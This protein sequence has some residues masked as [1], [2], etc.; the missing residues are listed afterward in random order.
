MCIRDSPY[1]SPE[2]LDSGEVD[3]QSDLWSLAVMLYEMVTGLQPYQAE[4]TER[5]ERMIRSHIAPPPAPEPC[6]EPMRRILMKAMAP[7]VGQRYGSAR[8]M[9]EDL[10]AFRTG[11]AVR[12]EAED[13]DATRRT[14]RREGD[15]TRRTSPVADKDATQRSLPRVPVK[16]ATWP[17]RKPGFA[18]WTWSNGMRLVAVLAAACLLMGLWDAAS[19]YRLYRAGKALERDMQAER[20]TDPDQIW[21]KWTELSGSNSASVLLSGPRGVVKQRLLTAANHVITLFRN[22]Q[23]QPIQDW[24]HARVM[25]ADVLSLDPDERVRGE[26]RLTEG[27]IACIS[28]IYHGDNK[29]LV[30]AV[31]KFTEAQHLMPTSPDP[32]L[33]LAQLYVY[34]MKDLDK[35]YDALRE[36]QKLGYSLGKREKQQ[37]AD[38][39]LDRA[40]NLLN[41]AHNLRGLPQEKDE[42]ERAA[43]DYKRALEL[44]QAIAPY[45]HATRYALLVETDLDGVNIRLTQIANGGNTPQYR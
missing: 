12:A 3:A 13:L 11:G 10:E 41:D 2:R 9:A 15:E 42:I 23:A 14:F 38:G 43:E 18:R 24:E 16:P 36:A 45:G 26:L 8:E 39:Y 27:Q 32:Q 35:A 6:A 5:L 4:N 1:A 7:E 31:E 30:T 37:L 22:G 29:D 44:Y 19:S 25:L 40:N 33:A 21:I 34:G 17:F 20:L 28:G